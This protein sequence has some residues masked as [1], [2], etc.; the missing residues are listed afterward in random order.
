MVRNTY[1]TWF[2]AKDGN[3]YSEIMTRMQGA[4]VSEMAG[5][6]KLCLISRHISHEEVDDSNKKTFWWKGGT[7]GRNCCVIMKHESICDDFHVQVGVQFLRKKVASEFM[8]SI[9]LDPTS[10][11]KV[12]VG[13][14]S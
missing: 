13:N 14:G 11:N 12:K 6:V 7:F 10:P 2:P 3:L 8:V 9:L 1:A 5:E 4:L